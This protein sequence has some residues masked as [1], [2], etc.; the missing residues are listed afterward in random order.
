[1]TRG[2]P[3]CASPTTCRSLTSDAWRSRRRRTST[4]RSVPTY[5]FTANLINHFDYETALDVVQR[6]FAQFEN[7]RRPSGGKRP[8]TDQMVARFHVLEELGFADGW[9]LNAQ[10]QLLRSIYHECDLLIAECPQCRRLRGSRRGAI[11]WPPLVFR[12]RIEAL[13]PVR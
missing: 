9:Q 1:M 10:G 8:L 11:G 5:N 2:T 3:L 4:R 7:D 6:S 13:N 12:V